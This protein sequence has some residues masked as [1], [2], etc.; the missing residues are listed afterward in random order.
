MLGLHFSVVKQRHCRPFI[1][2]SLH[3]SPLL[4]AF[5]KLR[6]ATISF[7]RPSTWTQLGSHWTDF[8]GISYMSIFLNSVVKNSSSTKIWPE[9]WLFTWRPIYNFD[10]CRSAFK[11]K[12]MVYYVKNTTI[13]HNY[14]YFIIATCF[15]HKSY[16]HT[17][18][19]QLYFQWV[20]YN[21]IGYNYR[22][23]GK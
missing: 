15:G 8:H 2:V 14:W 10:L 5:A 22:V 19:A 17:V 21:Y 11:I 9:S 18:I 1:P 3:A 6:K 7:V 4:G 12:Q 16:V 23:V 13:V 20:M